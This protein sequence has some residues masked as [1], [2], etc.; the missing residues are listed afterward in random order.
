MGEE[1]HINMN[2]VVQREA[3][4]CRHP[5]ECVSLTRADRATCEHNPW[6]YL[7]AERVKATCVERVKVTREKDLR[8]YV[9]ARSEIDKHKTLPFTLTPLHLKEGTRCST[10]FS[11]VVAL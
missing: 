9:A 10:L 1:V 3:S 2:D 4:T 8:S 5:A 6:L 11:P 7:R